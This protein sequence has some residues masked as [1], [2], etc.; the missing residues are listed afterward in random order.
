MIQTEILLDNGTIEKLDHNDPR[1]W[2]GPYR[3][4][5][6]PKALYRKAQPGAECECRVVQHQQEHSRLGSDWHESPAD[7]A[8]AFQKLEADIAKAAAERNYTDRRMSE[9]AQREALERDR[10]SDALM[11]EL[12]AARKKPGRKPKE[13]TQ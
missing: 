13:Q 9:S 8:E 5:E 4:E 12:P 3:K 10:A 7:A 2:Q 6:Y 1:Y 11:P